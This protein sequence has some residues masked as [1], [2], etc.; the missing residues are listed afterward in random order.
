YFQGF[1][2]CRCVKH[3]TAS[4]LAFLWGRCLLHIFPAFF[5]PLGHSNSS[6]INDPYGLPNQK[7]QLPHAQSSSPASIHLLDSV[8]SGPHNISAVDERKMLSKCAE[9][10]IGR[11]PSSVTYIPYKHRLCCC[12]PAFSLRTVQARRFHHCTPIQSDD[13]YSFLSS[14][15]VSEDFIHKPMATN[16]GVRLD[17]SIGDV[18]YTLLFSELHRSPTH[19][20]LDLDKSTRNLNLRFSPFLKAD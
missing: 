7:V 12:T 4:Q 5:L 18:V 11:H 8:D 15:F 1:F 16:C 13:D 9:T 2:F 17:Y 14:V 3:K 10:D 20:T 6:Q 19:L